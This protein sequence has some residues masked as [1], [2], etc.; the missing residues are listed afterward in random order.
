MFFF[1]RINWLI[2][3]PE[4]YKQKLLKL[5][6]KNLS[7]VSPFDCTWTNFRLQQICMCTYLSHSFYS[8]AMFHHQKIIST[9]QLCIHQ[10]KVTFISEICIIHLFNL[11]WPGCIFTVSWNHRLQQENIFC[12][13]V[14]CIV[15]SMLVAFSALIIMS[16]WWLI[17]VFC[18]VQ[19]I[20]LV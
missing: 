6:Y 15:Y 1:F 3:S 2:P 14:L 20:V 4:L 10:M 11:K 13:I 12:F 17:F 5:L 8:T 19:Y 16:F 9:S 7:K 18:G